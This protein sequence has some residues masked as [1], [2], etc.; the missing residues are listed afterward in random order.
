MTKFYGIP[1]SR[2]YQ[3]RVEQWVIVY[4]LDSWGQ[5]VSWLSTTVQ[6]LTSVL[7]SQPLADLFI[8]PVTPAGEPMSL[9]A[10]LLPIYQEMTPERCP[11]ELFCP[12]DHP[13]PCPNYQ[14]CRRVEP[15]LAGTKLLRQVCEQ[16]IT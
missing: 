14:E 12:V 8:E 5:P 4:R 10:A 15:A 9:Q 7:A 3:F 6:E 13:M 16:A 11:I 2:G 1:A